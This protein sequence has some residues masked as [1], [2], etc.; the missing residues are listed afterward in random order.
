MPHRYTVQRVRESTILPHTRPSDKVHAPQLFT[1][2]GGVLK[3][4]TGIN[5]LGIGVGVA[6]ALRVVC[7]CVCVCVRGRVWPCVVLFGIVW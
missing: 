6:V 2:S 1:R 5:L 3:K 7:V 4:C